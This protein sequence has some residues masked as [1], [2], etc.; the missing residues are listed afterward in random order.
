MKKLYLVFVIILFS[1]PVYAGFVQEK[2]GTCNSTGTPATT[3]TIT[4][5]SGA[6]GGNA[7]IVGAGWFT[8]AVNLT[9][10]DDKSDV[11]TMLPKG[12][13]SGGSVAYAVGTLFGVTSGAQVFTFTWSSTGST[14]SGAAVIEESGVNAIDNRSIETNTADCQSAS[15]IVGSTSCV[16][17]A[18]HDTSEISLAFAAEGTNVNWTI[19]GGYT[20]RST[21]TAAQTAFADQVVANGTFPAIFTV[22]PASGA[23]I[24]TLTLFQKDSAQFQQES[25]HDD[26]VA[27]QA[28][29]DLFA[30]NIPVVAGQFLIDIYVWVNTPTINMTSKTDSLGNTWNCDPQLIISG[31]ATSIECHSFASFSGSD[32]VTTNFSGSGASFIGMVHAA[33]QGVNAIDQN[34]QQVG[35]SSTWNSQ[36]VTTT[37][38][39]ELLIGWFATSQG[40]SNISSTAPWIMRATNIRSVGLQS[41]YLQPAGTYNASFNSTPSVPFSAGIITLFPFSGSQ[42]AGPTQDA[43][44]TQE[45]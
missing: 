23:A 36:S 13:V 31:G 38:P 32:T 9:V 37:H 17:G 33:F 30:Y 5:T 22:S 4:L 27:G 7:I 28:T 29:P 44:P 42:Q 25:D 2:D 8:P 11:I 26:G 35:S 19:G 16:A 43:G 3:C 34:A 21:A 20:L 39:N 10:T 15:T 18:T 41:Q 24:I 6:T 40:F 14:F 12:L 45:Q 1:S